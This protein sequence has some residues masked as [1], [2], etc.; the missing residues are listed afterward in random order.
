MITYLN[1]PYEHRH[2]AKSAGAKWNAARKL[3]YVENMDDLSS[4]QHWI[5]DRS[6]I[7]PH[8]ET[9]YEREFKERQVFARKAKDR[10]QSQVKKRR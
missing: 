4:V 5:I 10:K 9:P 8:K 7:Q 1:V 3:W 2:K 6:L